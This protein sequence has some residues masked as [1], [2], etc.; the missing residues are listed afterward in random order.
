M[1]KGPLSCPFTAVLS[2]FANCNHAEG[3]SVLTRSHLAGTV[4][5]SRRLCMICC[6]VNQTCAV[7]NREY[8]CSQQHRYCHNKCIKAAASH[9]GSSKT[10]FDTVYRLNYR[11]IWHSICRPTKHLLV[12]LNQA[13]MR[14]QRSAQRLQWNCACKHVYQRLLWPCWTANAL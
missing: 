9:K 13:Y 11:Q 1:S 5:R 6:A 7:A 3:P 8:A 2:L 4:E 14:L 10:Y 12:S